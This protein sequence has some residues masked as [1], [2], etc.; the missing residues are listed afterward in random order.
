MSTQ[1]SVV[2][3]N[4]PTDLSQQLE[5]EGSL[6][7]EENWDYGYGGEA[8]KHYQP[9]VSAIV[10]VVRDWIEYTNATDRFSDHD[11]NRLLGSL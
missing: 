3:A 10:Q 1:L 8:V 2:P 5:R 9:N 4:L 11:Y 6:L 7:V